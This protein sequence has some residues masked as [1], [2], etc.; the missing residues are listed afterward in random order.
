MKLTTPEDNSV[1]GPVYYLGD[2]RI[3]QLIQQAER[4]GLKLSGKTVRKKMTVM[5]EIPMTY[6]EEV[7]I[8][9]EFLGDFLDD[10]IGEL[11]SHEVKYHAG[12]KDLDLDEGLDREAR[13]IRGYE[14]DDA[15]QSA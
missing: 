5:L 15:E 9:E 14:L 12:L 2:R 3:A 6:E 1:K 11:L 10:D 4:E 7:E 13:S 8:P